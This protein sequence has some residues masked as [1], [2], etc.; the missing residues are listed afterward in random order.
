MASSHCGIHHLVSKHSPGAG[1]LTLLLL[2][3]ETKVQD[4]VFNS[5]K[6][7]KVV[8]IELMIITYNQPIC[9][10]L[11]SMFI[12]SLSIWNYKYSIIWLALI[13]IFMMPQSQQHPRRTLKKTPALTISPVGFG[14][15]MSVPPHHT[16]THSYL[17]SVLFLTDLPT[18]EG[19]KFKSIKETSVEVEWDPLDIAFETWEVIFRNMVRSTE[20]KQACSSMRTRKML[21]G[22]C[23]LFHQLCFPGFGWGTRL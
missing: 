21:M 23:R 20:E 11:T 7:T 3:E 15:M 6:H 10:I 19:L 9:L 4:I 5:T 18:P 13:L 16:R 12:L 1:I 17:L 8:M 22:F 14:G 2:G